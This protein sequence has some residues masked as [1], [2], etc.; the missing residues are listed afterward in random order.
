MASRTI[1][2]ALLFLAS[3]TTVTATSLA[4]D[5]KPSGR[6]IVG[7][8]PADI[9][10]YPWQVALSIKS[11]GGTYLCGGSILRPKWLLTAAHC[12][13]GSARP[14]NVRAK[15]GVSNY[16]A[17]GIWLE[18][19]RIFI[20]KG[21][22]SNT[23]EN[24]IAL[25]KLKSNAPGRVID[26]VDNGATI[27]TGQELEVTGWGTTAEG[28]AASDEL[29]R[30]KVPYVENST[31]N[32]RTSYNGAIKPGMMCAGYPNG[33]IDA[34][35][36]DSGGPLVWRTSKPLLVGVV[37]FGEGCARKMKFGIYTRVDA[38][39]DWI[40]KTISDGGG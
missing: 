12:F 6:R 24:D 27:P 30:A 3:L 1:S 21:Y 20:H 17:S 10:D 23:Q 32:A 40:E 7:G 25:I 29:M 18:A 28:G 5:F 14:N 8:E 31:C 15:A 2:V 16:Q 37:S 39:R 22:N 9:R 34:C 35:Q 13:G 36:G 4:E 11:S 33:A 26:L 38:Y 19:E